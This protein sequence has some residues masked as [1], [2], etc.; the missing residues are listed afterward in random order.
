M[1]KEDIKKI[2]EIIDEVYP[3]TSMG[4]FGL[5]EQMCIEVFK[6]AKQQIFGRICRW[7]DD[8]LTYYTFDDPLYQQYIKPWE[9]V[10]ILRKDMKE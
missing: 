6:Y 3:S 2:H 8:N 9:V 1:K 5:K 4:D 10:N 7:L